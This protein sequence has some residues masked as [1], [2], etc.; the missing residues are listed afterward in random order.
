[1]VRPEAGSEAETSQAEQFRQEVR[2]FLA[3]NLTKDLAEAPRTS[4]LISEVPQQS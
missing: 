2:A 3:A 1:M 4:L